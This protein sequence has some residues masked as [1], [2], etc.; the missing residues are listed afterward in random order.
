MSV[1]LRFIAGEEMCT[2]L[3]FLINR[4]VTVMR[5]VITVDEQGDLKAHRRAF[6]TLT[7]TFI[8]PTNSSD[9]EQQRR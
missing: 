7:V 9:G 6:L 3:T 2:L 4:R 1:N 8:T 5:R